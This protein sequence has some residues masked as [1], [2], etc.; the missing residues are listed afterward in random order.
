M[1]CIAFSLFFCSLQRPSRACSTVQRP[2]HLPG[3]APR[4]YAFERVRSIP[5]ICESHRSHP[6]SLS[7][8]HHTAF[9]RESTKDRDEAARVP[10][11]SPRWHR[12][13]P[14]P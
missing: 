8:D 7:R 14:V 2:A 1:L 3:A 12:T 13:S 5:A 10:R 9:F 6:T 11:T 4:E